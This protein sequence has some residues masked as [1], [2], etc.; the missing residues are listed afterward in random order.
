[1]FVGR[2]TN[3]EKL[4]DFGLSDSLV[5][6]CKSVVLH[7]PEDEG[8][9]FLQKIPIVIGDNGKDLSKIHWKL[10]S[11]ELTS[12]K[13][14]TIKMRPYIARVIA[15]MDLLSGGDTL[16]DDYER[17]DYDDDSLNYT[18]LYAKFAAKTSVR[19]SRSSPY[20]E[21]VNAGKACRCCLLSSG[22]SVGGADIHANDSLNK[23]RLKNDRLDASM[24]IAALRQK[25]TIIELLDLS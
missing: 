3:I 4:Y 13:R 2:N 19:A 12:L 22:Y 5:N 18:N 21:A 23:M 14:I 8:V 6:I 24:A 11:M 25:D 9:D 17:L 15:E 7:I 16:P 1:M 20:Y 10:L